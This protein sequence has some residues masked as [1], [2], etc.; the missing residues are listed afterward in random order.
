MTE[1]EQNPIV[2]VTPNNPPS[3]PIIIQQDSS[4]FPVSVVLG[5]TNYP[6]WSQLMEM[7]IRARNK[8]GYLTGAAVKPAPND[9]NYATWTT[10]N[11]KVKS[12]LIDSMSPHLM[13]RFIRLAT[14]KEIW[15]AVSRTFYDG[16]DET[17]LFDLNQ[18]SFSTTQNGRPLST[19]YNELVAIF[20]EI[21]HR[22]TSQEESVEGVVQLHS[23]MMRLRVHIFL[24]GLDPEYPQVRREI[25]RKD[26]K[27]DLEGTYAYVRR[28]SQQ[29][30][31]MGGSQILLTYLCDNKVAIQIA[32]NHVQHDQTKHVEV[33]RHFI[34]EKLDQR[35]ICFPFVKY[36]SQ[37][38]DIL[39]KAVSGKEFHSVIGKLGMINIY[40][41]T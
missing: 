1:Q 15:E 34:K 35:V 33:D 5:E 10:E 31:V 40:A 16:S 23:A 32:D 25:L 20:Q 3:A 29:R 21:D 4:A 8:V 30:Q 9:P 19:Y 14:T 36:A 11:H 27:L 38:T 6:L 17:Q 26:P 41:P 12:W 37:L 18:K 22:T 7:C 24:S 28:E 39:T 13:Q 2:P